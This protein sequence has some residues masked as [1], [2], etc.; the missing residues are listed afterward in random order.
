MT[1]DVLLNPIKEIIIR[2]AR[3]T[4]HQIIDVLKSIESVPSLNVVCTEIGISEASYY[5]WKVIYV[6]MKASDIR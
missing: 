2:K 5:N 3:F 4:R 1:S 6:W